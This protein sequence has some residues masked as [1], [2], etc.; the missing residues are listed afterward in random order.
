MPL[1]LTLGNHEG[2]PVNAFP[3]DAQEDS[4]VSG[5]W[6]YQVES[7][8]FFSFQSSSIDLIADDTQQGLVNPQWAD[9][10]NYN[11]DNN[12]DNDNN[13]NDNLYIIGRFCLSVCHEK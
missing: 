13:N 9:N 4:I 11:N 5:A 12:N 2:F 8:R 1:Y 3:T 10:N 7:V 6:L